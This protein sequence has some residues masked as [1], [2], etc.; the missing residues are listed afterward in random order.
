LQTQLAT[1]A[2][3]VQP[4]QQHFSDF[5]RPAHCHS[6]CSPHHVLVRWTTA[7]RLLRCEAKTALAGATR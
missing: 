3:S 6:L 5:S 7:C 2:G 1:W 4:R